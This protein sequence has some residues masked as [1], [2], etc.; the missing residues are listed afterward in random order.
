MENETSQNFPLRY[1][2]I[3][4]SCVIYKVTCS[5]GETY[6]G[7]TTGNASVRLKEHNNPTETFRKQ[8]LSCI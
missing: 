4:P 1:T 7:E 8:F 6:I 3:H 2:S 5:C